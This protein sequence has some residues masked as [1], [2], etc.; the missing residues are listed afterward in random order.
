MT[1]DQAIQI[2]QQI[3]QDFINMLPKSAQVPTASVA[4]EALETLKTKD[5]P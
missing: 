3:A 1:N 2:L 4:K 5:A